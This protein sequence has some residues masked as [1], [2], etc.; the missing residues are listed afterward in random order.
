MVIVG[1]G[2]FGGC[3]AWDAASRGLSIAVIERGDFGQATSANSFKMVHGGIRYLQHGDIVRL[4]QSSRER[5]AL[6]RLAPHLVHPLPIVIPTYGRGMKS[7]AAMAAAMKIYDWAAFDRNRGINDPQRMIP[8]GRSIS[9]GEVL[10]MFPGLEP[11]GLTGAAVF[12]DAQMYNPPRLVLAF[13]QSAV[14]AGAT[15]VNYVEATGFLKNGDRV[16]GIAARDTLTGESFDIRATETLNAAGPYA[17]H[18]LSSGLG[19]RLSPPGTY[20]RD[21]CLYGKR[22]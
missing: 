18:L 10:D 6:L 2:V 3:A 12:R 19:I 5:N 15:A 20:S 17:E 7:R 21:A 9:R 1:G 4:R 13:V 8:R 16:S 14:A 11:T 22:S